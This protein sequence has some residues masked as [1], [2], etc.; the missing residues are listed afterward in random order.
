MGKMGWEEEK[1]YLVC[2]TVLVE[3]EVL[4]RGMI[5]EYE[6]AAGGRS[7]GLTI[8]GKVFL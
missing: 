7:R 5:L 4:M 8:N 6:E 3:V 1:L 2:P